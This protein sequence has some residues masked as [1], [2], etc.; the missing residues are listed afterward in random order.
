M[1]KKEM[2]RLLKIFIGLVSVVCLVGCS[3]SSKQKLLTFITKQ[4]KENDFTAMDFNG[5]LSVVFNQN[6]FDLLVH[7]KYDLNNKSLFLENDSLGSLTIFDKNAYLEAFGLKV[8]VPLKDGFSF[9]SSNDEVSLATLA[10]TLLKSIEDVKV[11]KSGDYTNY[12]FALNVA[13][14]MKLYETK[15]PKVLINATINKPTIVINA[16]NDEKIETIHLSIGGSLNEISL[17][18]NAEINPNKYGEDVNILKP[19]TSS[20]FEMSLEQITK[21]LGNLNI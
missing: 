8:K 13:D 19:D 1:E 17:S 9:T 6:P 12:T 14:L 21:L 11:E 10:S 18:I 7:G 20:F 2:K 16:L 4:V 3:S 5:S 15:I